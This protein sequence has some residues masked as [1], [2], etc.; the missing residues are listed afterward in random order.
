MRRAAK[1]DANHGTVKR[2]FEKMGCSVGDL[3]R[4]GEGITD[5]VVGIHY[6]NFLVEVKVPGQGLR[7][8]KQKDFYR[9]WKGPK[10]IVRTVE[11]AALLVA[12]MGKMARAVAQV[13]TMIT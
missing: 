13:R 9:D 5:L 4:A 8:Q 1:V 10:A 3:S 2:A 11:E 12:E 6:V 7:G